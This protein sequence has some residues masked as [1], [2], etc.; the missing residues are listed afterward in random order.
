MLRKITEDTHTISIEGPHK[1]KY[2]HVYKLGSLKKEGRL[3]SY[4][5]SI[6]G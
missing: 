1:Y 5:D 2:P 4:F 6:V 3:D